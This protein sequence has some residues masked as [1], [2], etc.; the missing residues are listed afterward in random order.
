MKLAI[1][2][3][4]AVRVSAESLV[5]ISMEHD[6]RLAVITATG[7]GDLVDWFTHNRERVDDLHLATGA[8]LFRGFSVPD[9]LRFEAL[10]RTFSGPNRYLVEDQNTH[11]QF[12]SDD[13]NVW[14]HNDYCDRSTWPRYLVFWCEQTM[15]S[16]GQTPF[17]DSTRVY[18]ALPAAMRLRF[19]TEGWILRRR[20][21]SG[22]GV[23]AKGF[24]K[25]GDTT[26]IRRQVGLLDAFDQRWDGDTLTGFS[27]RFAPSFDHPRTMAKVWANNITFSNIEMV[28]ASIREQLLADYR[29][30]DLPVTTLW[31]DGSPISRADIELLS[32]LY[33]DNEVCFDW[34]QGDVLLIDNIRCVHGR[35]PILAPQRVNVGVCEFHT[36]INAAI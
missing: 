33:R 28:E 20:F 4:T 9:P 25:T 32:E 7:A 27:A 17:V 12:V 23:D 22:I 5:T 36:R 11:N 2:K 16:G 21:H 14:F 15:A 26:E 8:V 18:Q 10:V 6:G 30:D 3:A 1:G 31:G 29:P 35:R 24:F 34:H 19:E 13:E